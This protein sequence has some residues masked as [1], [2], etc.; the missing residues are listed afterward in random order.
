MEKKEENYIFLVIVVT[1]KPGVTPFLLTQKHWATPFLITQTCGA[2]PFFGTQN[3]KVIN[4]CDDYII[5]KS[6]YGLIGATTKL[7]LPE[8]KQLRIFRYQEMKRLHGFGLQEMERLRIFGLQEME[9][10]QVFQLQLLQ[11]FF[12]F[13]L[14]CLCF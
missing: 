1:Q 4:F 9:W 6:I 14:F 12:S 10:L 3:A 5:W 13:C 2:T 7:G 8:T 11:E